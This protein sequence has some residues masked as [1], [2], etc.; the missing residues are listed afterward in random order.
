VN[1]AVRRR[2]KVFSL[3]P[4]PAFWYLCAILFIALVLRM[5]IFL[6]FP[7]LY[8]P[9][10]IFQTQEAGHRLAFGYGVIPWEFR[11]GV[12]SWVLPALI[13]GIMK[14]AAWLSSGSSGYIFGICLFFSLLSLTVVWFSFSWCR[15]YLGMQYALLAAF[16]TAI[17]YELVDSGPRTLSEYVAG[18]LFL[19]AIY[20][21][22]LEPRENDPRE[23][24]PHEKPESKGRLLLTG[25]LL[26][27]TLALRVQFGPAVLLAAL[28]IVY[29]NW[30]ARSLPVA[31]GIAIVLSFFGLV[32]AV[33]WSLP[34]YS[35]YAYFRENLLHH[36]AADFGTSPWYYYFRA[37]L[38]KTGPMLLFAL[39]G[40][41]RA[42][43]LG[44]I[45]LAILL[46]HLFIA[47]KEYRF[48]YP[49]VPLL[50]TLATIGIVDSLQYLE[51]KTKF[52]LPERS[53]LPLA[54][55]F[56]LASSLLLSLRYS[57]WKTSRGELLAFNRL[58]VDQNACGVA[59]RDVDI[60][61]TG[62]Y[63]HLHR[64][65]PIFV[66]HNF[67]DANSDVGSFNR[68]V[69]PESS[70]SP[71]QGYSALS[72]RYSVCV[73]QRE[74]TCQSTASD[75]EINEF[76]KRRDEKRMKVAFKWPK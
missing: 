38:S 34:F 11:M 71:I 63:T 4:R 5:T 45:C 69:A 39:I 26:G 14:C 40:I 31:A 35:Y 60:S 64:P 72:C 68:L 70:A 66:F 53:K 48:I 42:P 19:P 76:I 49:V 13:A 6:L 44:W 27:L 50:L 75:H 3:D 21:G 23:N 10:E 17:W 56:V 30:K 74:G 8:Y 9:D 15:R 59:I 28:W 73:Y 1:V 41:R 46:P 32:D 47:H 12:R 16:T 33:T 58:S 29:R 36:R 65:I 20:L 25:I 2:Q 22:S 54:A 18:N 37:L 43:I 55:S 61:H 24:D 52:R 67:S 51:Q 57:D 62:G 7:S